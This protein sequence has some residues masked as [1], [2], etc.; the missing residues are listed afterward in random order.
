M[1]PEYRLRL[2]GLRP[3]DATLVAAFLRF[4]AP[5]SPTLWRIC[6]DAGEA[7]PA[8][9]VLCSARDAGRLPRPAAGRVAY[10]ADPDEETAPVLPLLFR[11]LDFDTFADLL[12]EAEAQAPQGIASQAPAAVSPAPAS[13]P[14]PTAKAAPAPAPAPAPLA[15]EVA[16]KDRS[17]TYKLR[18]WPS[19]EQLEG[20][21]RHKILASFLAKRH[22]GIEQLSELSGMDAQFCQAFLNRML[23]QGLLDV[24]RQGAAAPAIGDTARTAGAVTGKPAGNR[25]GIAPGSVTAKSGGSH[26]G[27][28][29]RS[30]LIL[31][32]RRRLGL[33]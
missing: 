24:R 33:A 16:A 23:A 5:E 32:L 19:A 22:L 6:T 13:R 8:D 14:V 21:R 12:R 31:K 7:M 20:E 15:P 18:S 28:A 10:V 17:A 9:L 30:D 11:P 1:K 29:A 3:A 25:A 26:T 27:E 4:R 2:E